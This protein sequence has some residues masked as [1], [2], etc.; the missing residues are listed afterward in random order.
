VP[1]TGRSSY[2][3]RAV[4]RTREHAMVDGVNPD[5]TV[6][7][8]V[9]RG[10]SAE[11]HTFPASYLRRLPRVGERA[12]RSVVS[13]VKARLDLKAQR[14][15]RLDTLKSIDQQRREHA[16]LEAQAKAVDMVPDSPE[17]RRLRSQMARLERTIAAEES[18]VTELERS[19]PRY[20]DPWAAP[21]ASAAANPSERTYLVRDARGRIFWTGRATSADEAMAYAERAVA[22]LADPPEP[23][24]A[25]KRRNP[26]GGAKR[27]LV[28]GPKGQY[29]PRAR[30]RAT[31]MRRVNPAR[32]RD[33]AA[34]ARA[35]RVVRSFQDRGA[36]AVKTKAMKRPAPLTTTAAEL[37]KL[38]AVTYRTDKFDG[39]ERDYEHEF[40]TLPSLVTDPEGQGLH[41]V[42]GAFKIT[43]DGI[44]N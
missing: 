22:G 24:R 35:A 32:R 40:E 4:K 11:Q 19:D 2:F 23:W 38:V 41:I 17:Y 15:R 1:Y 28:G 3:G 20:V 8:R 31:G 29:R 7:V 16:C 13:G 37:G 21:A 12:R 27:I 9:T 14:R 25:E 39:R 44:V 42:G 26:G 10:K 33:A 30:R 18:I 6:L 5:G 36:I 43:P 34:E